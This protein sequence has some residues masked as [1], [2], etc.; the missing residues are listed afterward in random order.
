[1][2]KITFCG[3]AGTV[4]GSCFLYTTSHDE[5]ILVDCGMYQGPKEIT[6]LNHHEFAFDPKS[7]QTV[8]LT[9]AHLDHCG[10]LPVLYRLGCT[11][12]LY[13]TEATQKL[14]EITLYDAAAIGQEDHGSGALFTQS[15]VDTTLSFVKTIQ[16]HTPFVV[17]QAHVTY[18]DA[19]HILGAAS[20]IITDEDNTIA[21]S[22]DLGNAPQQDIV[23]ISEPVRQA[24]TVI[25]ESTYGDR[26]HPVDEDA[27]VILADLINKTQQS[28]GTLLIPAFSIERTQDL[29]HKID[30]LKKDTKIPLDFPVFLDS[31]MGMR[32]TEVYED[33]IT[34]LSPEIQKH[35]L[36]DDP[37]DFPGLR[38]VR[39]AQES[40]HIRTLPMPKAIIAGSGM[41]SGGR[42]VGHAKELLSDART[43]LLIT[44]YQGEGT[45]GRKLQ[46]GATEVEIDDTVVPVAATIVSMHSLSAHADQPKL[47]EWVE[48]VRG[49]NHVFLV[50]GEDS[51]RAALSEKLRAKQPSLVV[52]TPKLD[53]VV[54]I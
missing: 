52:S 27:N 12:P 45:L 53:E 30:H 25:V 9:H 39:K 40:K 3:A 48:K 38:F 18:I 34:S 17:G 54:T 42:V 4:T 21:F 8:L 1:M 19:G 46:E 13:M 29:I 16:L 41:M 47:I 43:T 36:T 50:H 14:L 6:A 24:D 35:N 20:I 49:V 7:V 10:R 22:G 31:P 26:S 32:T 51:S 2:R 28:G 15:D 5:T 37:F 44:G 23:N 11:A 33:F